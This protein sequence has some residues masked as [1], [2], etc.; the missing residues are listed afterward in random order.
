MEMK[1]RSEF[2]T[3]QEYDEYCEACAI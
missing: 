1:T 3:Q 2:N